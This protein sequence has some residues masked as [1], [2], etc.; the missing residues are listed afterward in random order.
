MHQEP[1]KS[2]IFCKINAKR[3]PASWVYRDDSVSAF[4]DIQP[5]NE[6][7]TLL[8]SR[9]H[10]PS[11]SDL[12]DATT[13]HLFS[14]AR[15]ITKALYKTL[16]CDGVNWIVADGEAAGQEVF[17]F[18]LHIIPRYDNDGFGFQFPNRYNRLPARQA[19]DR[20]AHAIRDAVEG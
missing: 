18:H 8:L 4:M 3:L 20:T 6:G 15:R 5:V 19:L 2:C 17:H 14:I 9:A 13:A 12:D 1:V 7:H 10:A 11:V 16:G